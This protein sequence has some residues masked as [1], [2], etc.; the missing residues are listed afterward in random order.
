MEKV[1]YPA[2]FEPDENGAYSV[3]FPDIPGAVTGGKNIEDSYKMAFNCL[4]N[5]LSYM[6]ENKEPIPAPSAP[7]K[8]ETDPGQFLVVIEFDMAEYKRKNGSHAVKK[9]LSIPS[10][11]NEEA[12]ARGINF[13]FVLQEALKA[14]LGL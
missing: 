2:I 11:L 10:W 14:E 6:T 7:E 12:T 4:G 13:S 9:T 3:E 1:F 8:I 5:I